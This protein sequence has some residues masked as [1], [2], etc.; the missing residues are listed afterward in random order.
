[1]KN[2]QVLPE[3]VELYRDRTWRRTADNIVEDRDGAERLVESLGFVSLLTDSR[4]PGPSLYVAVCGRRDAH[5][6]RNTHKDPETSLAWRLK[7]EV[8]RAGRVYY[9]KIPRARSTFVAVRLIPSFNALWGIP[10]KKESEVLS[11][12][13][14]A[15]LKVL[16]KEWEMGTADLR[17]ASGVEE[18]QQ[19]TRAMEELQRTMKVVPAEVIYDPRFTYIWTLAEGRFPDQMSVKA[20]RKES[21]REVARAY[22]TAAGMTACGELSRVTGLSRPDAGIGNHQL[23]EEGFAERLSPGV[24][25]LAG[26]EFRSASVGPQPSAS[27][28]A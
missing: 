18:R 4:Q 24:Y 23:V 7:D 2:P 3:E 15:I 5:M 25:C 26:F 22:L 20:S 28:Q 19:F 21:L 27:R 1:M 17:E 12:D 13:A 10:R 8:M 9:A 16:R 6:P 14:R 11:S